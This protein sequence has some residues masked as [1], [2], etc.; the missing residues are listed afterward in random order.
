MRLS[1]ISHNRPTLGLEEKRAAERV[2]DS[3]WVAQGK[4]VEI[5]ENELCA[6]LGL[7]EA[8][9]VAVSSGT[10]AL[11][12][13][14]WVTGAKGSTVACPVYACSALVN[15][16]KFAGLE[17]E[18]VDVAPNSPNVDV[19][20]FS[21]SEAPIAI[22]VHMF[23]QPVDTVGLKKRVIVE[24]CAQAL[25]ARIHG[26][27]VGVDGTVAVF[28]FH[29]TK[30][31]TSGGEGGMLVSTDSSLVAA[32]R[33]F[34]EFDY[35]RDRKRRF[36]I[37][38]TDLQAA[39]GREQLK[40]VS[41]F[42]K[43]RAEIFEL[44]RRAGLDLIDVPQQ[45]EPVRYRTVFRTKN[46][47]SVIDALARNGIKAIVPVEEWEL[48]ADSVEFPNAEYLSQNTVSLPTYPLLCNEDV[49]RIINALDSLR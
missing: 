27:P 22:V 45:G 19:E 1:A 6:H 4:E 44:Y 5:F 12:L 34:R 47:R 21:R 37:Q 39:I 24:D 32:A 11:F 28:S 13:A 40:K 48:L 14:L 9:A 43:R 23:G 7:R 25:G 17:P 15:A 36:N 41:S 46:P 38:M 30:I 16:I 20:A 3:G 31:I 49:F 42:I 8:H 2:L 35:R 26:R 10:A 29:A 33:D 18:F